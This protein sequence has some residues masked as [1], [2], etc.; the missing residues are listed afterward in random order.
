MEELVSKNSREIIVTSYNTRFRDK[1]YRLLLDF[2]AVLTASE[3][4]PLAAVDATAQF[5]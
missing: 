3:P 4:L 1:Y 5:C 2:T